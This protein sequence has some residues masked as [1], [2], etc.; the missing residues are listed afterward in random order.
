MSSATLTRRLSDVF[1]DVPRAEYGMT[2]ATIKNATGAAVDFTKEDLIGRPVKFVTDH[3]ELAI[4]GT[5]EATVDGLIYDPTEG[6]ALANNA[7]STSKFVILRRGPALVD[8]DK[9]K[10]GFTL[11][12][13]A[14][15]LAGLNPPIIRFTD[16]SVKEDATI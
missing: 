13:L 6:L 7:T 1:I 14:T 16:A 4:P 5:D 8:L 3:W 9:I 15:A 12:T 10:T 11:A 2:A